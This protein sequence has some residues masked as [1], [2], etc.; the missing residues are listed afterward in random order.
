MTHDAPSEPGVDVDDV[1]QLVIDEL[2]E[3]EPQQFASVAGAADAAEGQV[4]LDLGRI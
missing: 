2:L 3:A 1:D 4:G